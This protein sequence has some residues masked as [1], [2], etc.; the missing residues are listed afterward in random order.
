MWVAISV[1]LALAAFFAGDMADKC[2]SGIATAWEA[3]GNW[4]CS[5]VKAIRY[6][7]VGVPG[8]YSQATGMIGNGKCSFVEKPFSGPLSPFDEEVSQLGLALE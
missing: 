4:Y 1:I 7:N 8:T 2:S 6:Q 5:P 3:D